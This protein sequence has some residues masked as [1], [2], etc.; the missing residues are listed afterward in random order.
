M[1]IESQNLI[2]A[3]FPIRRKKKT[4][5]HLKD[6]THHIAFTEEV[7]TIGETNIILCRADIT[8]FLMEEKVVQPITELQLSMTLLY[9]SVVSLNFDFLP[10]PQSTFH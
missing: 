2:G 5:L 4:W 6:N 9:I 8:K 3:F 7:H 1:L 10:R